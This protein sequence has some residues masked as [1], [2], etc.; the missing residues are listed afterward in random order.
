VAKEIGSL[1]V[2]VG[3]D[4]TGFQNGLGKL[5]TEMK[6]V[7]SEFKLASTE[8]GKHGKE[9]DG[10]K[11]KSDSLTKQTEIQRQKVDAL[12]QAHEKSVETK[13]KDAKATQELEIKLN[14]AQAKLSSMEQSL[15]SLN[16]E[17]EL[18]SNGFYKLSQAL[19]PVGA[20]M[21]EIGHKMGS[22]GKD[23]TKKVT[24]PLV[25]VG[26]A[27]AKVGSDFQAGMSEVQAISG[28]TGNDLKQLEEK[29][30]EMGA[31]TKFSA[32]ESAEALKYM[33]MAG[34]DTNQMVAGLDGVMML[35]AA[36]GESLGSVSDIVTD[37]LTAFGM[38][39]K[40]ASSFADLLAS[41]SS[42]SNT[43]V[44]LLGESFK[45][46]APLFG[47]MGYSAEDAALA[48]GLMANSGIKG[49]QAGT[50]LKTA[51]ANLANPTDK[52]KG[53]MTDLGISI[54]DANGE[55]LPFKDV[56]DDLR[57]KFS[58]LTEEQQ[59]QYAATIFG[60]EAMSGMLA[61]INATDEDYVKLTGAT[62]EY[63]GVAKEMAETM[64]DNL[65]GGITKLKSALEG[66]GIQI[67][68]ILL[69]HLQSLVEKLQ[70]VVEWFANLSPATQETIVKIALVAAAIGPLLIIGGKL[71]GGIGTA[72]SAVATVSGAIAVATTGAVAA[73]PAIGALAT[74]FTVL[75]G[76]VGLA[77]AAI[78]ALTVA[79]VALYKHLNQE[80][81]PEIQ[82][83]GDEVSE[84]TKKA[85]GGFLEL[86]DEATI[87][88]NQLSWSGQEVTKEMADKITGNFS[89]M[90]ADIQ[91]GLDSHH[92]E[93][94]AKI[95][96]FINN[97]TS[98]SK[99]EQEGIINNMN[100]GYESRKQKVT[101]G[102][103]RI[104][105]ILETASTEKRG[106]TK[107]EQ[108]EINSIQEEMV[109]TGI[110]V[111]SENEVEAKSIMERMKA[112]AGEI[113]AKQAAEVV[114]NS[115]EQKDKTV[116]AAN[117]QYDEVVKEIIRQRDEAGT[118]TKDQADRLIKEATRQK[119]DTV[120]KA[121]EMHTDVIKEAK[122]QAK[123]H[124]NQ[125]DWETGEIK[126][127]WQVMK[128]DIAQKS[129]DIKEDVKKKWEEIKKDSS[130]KWEDIKTD[131]ANKWQSMKTDTINKAQ[132]IKTS[133]STKWSE[134]KTD[135]AQKWSDIRLDVSKKAGDIKKKIIDS[136][137][138]SES[139]WVKK[140]ASMLTAAN[141]KFGSMATKVSETFTTVVNS[142]KSGIDKLIEWNKQKVEDKKATFT[143]V[144]KEITEKVSAVKDKIVG[145]YSGTSFFQGGLTMVG[146][147]GPELV[148]LPRGSR[149]YNDNV[150]KKMLSG[151]KGITQHIVI[152]SPKH[153]SP[154]ETARKV[155]NAS[156]E[157]AM[158][159]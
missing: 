103:A 66:V 79:G 47:A 16:K 98:L 46:V 41:A 18:Q 153:L 83:F 1:N 152:N 126:T 13:G 52:M 157:L 155:K 143:T 20:K 8:L 50:S 90:A 15:S 128:T 131:T 42:N 145:N 17:I 53:A 106:I 136:I 140:T 94:L 104:K 146:E 73:T 159:W 137:T 71:I 75:T 64:E 101:D 102:E 32:T 51:I 111:L 21:Q 69:P 116:K 48:L 28:A 25:A 74:V 89:R 88:L 125:V 108:E 57:T 31:T 124:V 150:S 65:K 158:E 38:E 3:L 149:I 119:D 35:A 70:S 139:E 29:A 95:E 37:A 92:Q 93:S 43:N 68:E 134:I 112:Q 55:M 85:V 76:P 63:T 121:E 109:E 19:E 82:L 26:T 56:M 39:A 27:A 87:A 7:Q 2:V 115:I 81:I 132:E 40:D 86:N 72:I 78:A 156:K 49:S 99:E 58:G 141:D 60:K 44:G 54:T 80:S 133:V 61:I 6:K 30:K 34:W 151:D 122:A 11:L 144:F 24:L 45:Y 107:A 23:L 100:E 105:E 120:K 14:N 84:S 130:K 97:S 147:L 142:I 118:I 36:S 10:L 9:L 123:E 135:T 148:E 5:N 110:R 154:Y 91:A 4:A 138:D 77:V 129:K 117:E 59:A 33:A 22:V 96:G 67:F 113:T 12:K 127:K 114:K 62:R